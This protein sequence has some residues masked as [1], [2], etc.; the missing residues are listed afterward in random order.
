MT[1]KIVIENKALAEL[2]KLPKKIQR[3]I[4]NKIDQLAT[5]THPSGC[6]VLQKNNSLYRIR[7]GD[8]RIVYQIRENEVLVLVVR[9]G[10]RKDI[11]R[12]LR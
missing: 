7:S 2:A 4:A 12:K 8:Y 9:I 6:K 11:Y 3:Q 1:Y 10:H 5:N